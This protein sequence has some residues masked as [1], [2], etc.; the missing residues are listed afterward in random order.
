MEITT[1]VQRIMD[2][3][4]EQ[5]GISSARHPPRRYLWTDAHAVCNFLSLYRRSDEDK[6]R[7]LA[8]GLIDQVHNVLGRHRE[9]DPRSGWISGLSDT[10][11]RKHPTAGGLRI[12]KKL[13]ERRIGEAFD[14]ALEW[15]RDGQY[16][17][18]LTKW[19]HALSRTSETT[20]DARY[21]GW[22]LELAKAAHVGFTAEIP[23]G[24]PKRL[25]WK[26]SIDLSYP[27]VPATGL[28]DPLDAYITYNE[29]DL[30]ATKYRNELELPDLD[31]EIAEAAAMTTGQRW[32]T[33]DPLGL[34]GLLFDLCRVVQLTAAGHLQNSAIVA[35]LMEAATQSLEAFAARARLNDPASRR[36]AFRE[37][38]LSIGLRAVPTLRNV[39][40]SHPAAFADGLRQD[41]EFL[42]RFIPLGEAI[43]RFWSQPENQ[44]VTTWR[45]HL[46]I[47]RVML[48]TS[49]LPDEFLR[50]AAPPPA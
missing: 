33:D 7:Q 11:G 50:V 44:Q 35:A 23:P 32:H 47:N 37:L 30:H 1:D 31:A 20:A 13:N 45:D 9:D 38:G 39:L 5:T 24:T 12:G 29:L 4:A 6:Y 19:M 49:L 16:F 14:D 8:L 42:A 18:Y 25:L 15:D 46:D 36:L 10:V 27:L 21:C 48:A 34:G 43:E 17:H 28:H 2:D 22:A 3:F 26:M 40:A 41:V